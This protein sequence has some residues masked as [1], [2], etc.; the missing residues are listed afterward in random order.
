MTKLMH[1][2]GRSGV[3]GGGGGGGEGNGIF[4]EP[5]VSCLGPWW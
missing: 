1:G 2:G 4:D 5:Q 3:G